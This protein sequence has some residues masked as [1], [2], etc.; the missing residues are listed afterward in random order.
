MKDAL[1]Y[2]FYAG[3]AFIAARFFAE[4]LMLALAW[5]RTMA[6]SFSRHSGESGRIL[7]GHMSVPITF[8]LVPAADEDASVFAGRVRSALASRYPEFEVIASVPDAAGFPDRLAGELALRKVFAVPRR[9]LRAPEPAAVYKAEG[10]P[11]LTVAASGTSTRAALLNA[12]V[13]FSTFPLVCAAQGDVSPDA[14]AALMAP[15]AR[16]PSGCACS[17][18]AVMPG[19][20]DGR[21]A[22]FWLNNTY[23][24]CGTAA[25]VSIQIAAGLPDI[26]AVLRKDSI[27]AAGGF[28]AAGR[29]EGLL[30]GIRSGAPVRGIHFT[31]KAAGRTAPHGGW[32]WLAKE[33][34]LGRNAAQ[35]MGR[36]AAA[37]GAVPPI[38]ELGAWFSAGA[39]WALGAVPAD[40]LAVFACLALGG[41]LLAGAAALFVQEVCLGLNMGASRVMKCAAAAF[42]EPFGPR[43]LILAARAASRLYSAFKRA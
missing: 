9:L 8:V 37:A 20:C 22:L 36:I 5:S 25:G 15:F 31:G 35:R 7:A 16:D 27:I 30:R 2:A 4:F 29:L 40:G 38:L 33:W 3:L 32:G 17:M 11:R 23:R 18:A 43:Q 28:G 10:E 6:G 19:D 24:V 1:P 21:S 39:A 26:T 42:I 14:V 13:N 12:A 34:A 41:G